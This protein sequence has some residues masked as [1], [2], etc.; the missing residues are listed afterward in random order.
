MSY[1]VDQ[2]TSRAM[3]TIQTNYT[4]IAHDNYGTRRFFTLHKIAVTLTRPL[5]DLLSM[6]KL[7]ALLLQPY[8]SCR[9]IKHVL[10]ND[11]YS[12]NTVW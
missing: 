6:K 1:T 5:L 4:K 12:I 3:F 10:T 11:S 2:Q 9:S 8:T 7:G